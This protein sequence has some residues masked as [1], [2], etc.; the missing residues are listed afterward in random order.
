MKKTTTY[1]LYILMFCFGISLLGCSQSARPKEPKAKEGALDLSHWN[2]A[3]N[4]PAYI[5]GEWEFHWRKFIPLNP[6]KKKAA[7]HFIKV[8]RVWNGYKVDGEKCTGDG[9]AT[10]RLQVKI[11]EANKRYSLKFMSVATAYTLYI[12]GK[13]RSSIGKVSKGTHSARPRYQPQS[14]DF[15]PKKK[16]LDVILRVSNY[17]HRSGGLWNG[18]LLGQEA[19]IRENREKT[20]LFDFFLLG[21]ILI[22]AFYHL[23]LFSL[24]QEEIAPL[25]F[26]IFCLIIA[27]RLLVTGERYLVYLFPQTRWET[28]LFIEYVTTYLSVPSFGLFMYSLFPKT[29]HRIPL[30]L[31][32]FL[33]SIFSILTAFLPEQIYTHMMPLFQALVLIFI[34]YGILSIVSLALRGEEGTA[35]FLLGFLFIV[36]AATNDILDAYEIIETGNYIALGLFL[37]ILTQAYLLSANYSKAFIKTEKLT[38]SYSRF[39]P[40]DFLD[41][42]NKQSILDVKLGDHIEKEMSILFSDIRSFTTLSEKMNPSQN[43]LFINEYL[44]RMSPIVKKNKGVIDK[45]IGDAIMALFIHYPD[46]AVSAAVEMQQALHQYNEQRVKDGDLAIQ[47]GIGINTGKMMLGTIGGSQRM[48]GTVI[49]DAVNLAA[50]IEGMTKMYGASILITDQT[51]HQLV[52]PYKYTTRMLDQVIAKGKSEPVIVFEILD[53]EPQEKREKKTASRPLFEKALYLYGQKKFQETLS[54]MEQILQDHPED[55]AAQIYIQRC[56]KYLV[57]GVDEHWKS[58]AKLDQK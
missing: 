38:H 33:G 48:E 20:L 30:L 39:V 19:Q 49:S 6:T 26:A 58:V 14:V 11:P 16:T 45:Y 35:V 29:I 43:F 53:G 41:L 46:D 24:R 32:I 18:I 40:H 23:G 28:I 52:D 21:S 15:I 42:L 51:L 8:P 12:N 34:V 2:F 55:K 44:K 54:I 7:T 27:A 5:N 9:Y 17:H 31:C 22:M 47:I 3:E 36:G 56:Q 4:G 25:Y 37:F 57:E 13:K 50:R 10:Y 1:S